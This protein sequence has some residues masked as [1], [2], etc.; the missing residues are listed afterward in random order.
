MKLT[1]AAAALLA[2]AGP[3]LAVTVT[4]V[5]GAPDPGLSPNA[6]LLAGFDAANLAGVT[7]TSSGNVITG[8]GSI[9]GVRAAPAGTGNGAYRS[10]GK[11]GSNTFDFAG[12]T[13]GKPLSELSL[14]WGSIDSFNVVDFLRPDNS[15]VASVS[16]SMLPQFNGNQTQAITNRRVHFDFTSS[17][18]VT[19]LRL[20]STGTAFEFDSIAGVAVPEPST[21]ALMIIGFG[22]IGFAMRR[23][24]V[25]AA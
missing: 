25:V 12:W 9:G 1:L 13:G 20:R 2:F 4:S 24:R 10:I 11:G 18:N 8:P 23:R 3:A 22:A 5:P 15:L 21:W 16:G 17:D 7:D 6:T 14:Y 19:R